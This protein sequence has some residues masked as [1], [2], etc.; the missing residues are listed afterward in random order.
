VVDDNLYLTEEDFDQDVYD[1]TG[2]RTR[3]YKKQKQTGSE[4]LFFSKCGGANETWASAHHMST[5]SINHLNQINQIVE[6]FLSIKSN[7]TLLKLK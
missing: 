4:A 6:F 2:K 3:L 7:H 5:Q 1:G